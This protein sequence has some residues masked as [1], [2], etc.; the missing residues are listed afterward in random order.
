MIPNYL[1]K[2]VEKENLS[3]TESYDAMMRIMSGDVS[4]VL[5]SGFL[6]ALKSKGESAEEVSGFVRAM[7]EKSIKIKI[8]DDNAI[9]VCGTG[10]DNSGTFNISTA[11]AFVVAG[12]GVKVAKHGNRSISSNSGSADV[13]RE[14]GVN[15]E[16]SPERAEAALNKIGITF[17]FAPQYHPAMKHAAAV[18]KDLGTRTVFNILGPLTNPA[19]L[20]RQMIGT[21]NNKTAEL[22]RDAAQIL[23]YTKVKFIC[24]SN[25]FDEILLDQVTNVYGYD[26]RNGSIN[27]NL[28]NTDFLYPKISRDALLCS[29]SKES[30][31]IILSVLQNTSPNGA[32]HTVSANAAV[33]LKCAGFSESLEVCVAAAEESIR[34][35][36]A[37]YKLKS[38]IDLSNK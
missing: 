35:E 31:M 19:N 13:L 5:L 2:I 20:K 6:I 16:M 12:A 26:I 25:R 7:R 14:L 28:I 21:F 22:L 8:D 9:D 34:S 1:A 17:L 10:G 24:S 15:I 32:F 36:A 38:L 29:S 27:Y 23:D 18:R 3:I 33:A 30:A 4:Q 11:V 37:Y